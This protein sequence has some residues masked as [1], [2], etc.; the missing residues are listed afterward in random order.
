MSYASLHSKPD[1][2]EKELKVEAGY[3]VYMIWACLDSIRPAQA[4]KDSSV[5]F[6]QVSDSQIFC[7]ALV[8]HFETEG[9]NFALKVSPDENTETPSEC[10]HLVR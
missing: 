3:P 2:Q 9:N 6:A 1:H 7:G 8:E 10:Y 5:R 4:Q